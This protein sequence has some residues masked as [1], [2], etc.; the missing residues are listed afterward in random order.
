M[1]NLLLLFAEIVFLYT[2]DD[3]DIDGLNKFVE[4]LSRMFV[5]SNAPYSQTL[6]DKK[7]EF[8]FT[9]AISSYYLTNCSRFYH[10]SFFFFFCNTMY[11]RYF[12]NLYIIGLIM[13]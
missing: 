13:Q 5:C 11:G 4:V 6:G 7:C 1:F 9:R 8:S 3:F 10:D 2:L 12:F